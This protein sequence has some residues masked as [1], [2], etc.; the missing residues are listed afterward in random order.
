LPAF[1][2][3]KVYRLKSL[4]ASDSS[5]RA[6]SDS[7]LIMESNMPGATGGSGSLH[8]HIAQRRGIK[9]KKPN[10]VARVS[11]PAPVTSGLGLHNFERKFDAVAGGDTRATTRFKGHL[12]PRNR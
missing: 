5:K 11:P 8:S 2:Q 7:L 4:K 10:P 6:L 1:L 12:G 9:A 3:N